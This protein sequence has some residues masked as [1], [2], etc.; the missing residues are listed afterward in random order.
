MTSVT[1]WPSFDSCHARYPDP[2]LLG[3]QIRSRARSGGSA[4]EHLRRE[5]AAVLTGH[6]PLDALDDG[7][8]RAAIV[9][10]LSASC[11]SP[12]SSPSLSPQREFHRIP[13]GR[14]ATN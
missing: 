5:L 10:E 6:G 7:R 8:D 1:R 13:P 4:G 11:D 12:D 3:P 2:A 14:A 9:L